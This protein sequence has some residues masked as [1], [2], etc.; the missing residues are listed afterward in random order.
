MFSSASII[1]LATRDI[2]VQFHVFSKPKLV[3]RYN[4]V[5]GSIHPRNILSN[6]L[7]NVIDWSV[8]MARKNFIGIGVKIGD[9]A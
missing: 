7:K 1:T 2:V 5:S 9:W 8:K 4:I 3:N 6:I